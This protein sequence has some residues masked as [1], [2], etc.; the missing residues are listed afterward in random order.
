VIEE[1]C[2]IAFKIGLTRKQVYLELW[3]RSAKSTIS[4][5]KFLLDTMDYE[6]IK[7]EI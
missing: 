7:Q 3:M 1:K 4:D 6:T 5:Y 2:D